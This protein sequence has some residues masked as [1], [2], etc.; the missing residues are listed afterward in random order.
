MKEY[1]VL[2]SGPMIC[3]LLAGNKTQTR[4]TFE[5][6]KKRNPGE[7]LWVREKFQFIQG[8][9]D[10]DFGIHY[11]ATEDITEWIDNEGR[12]PQTVNEKIR[13]SIHMPR[14]AS[15]IN[16]EIVSIREERLQ[17]IS[18]EDAM[19]EGCDPLVGGYPVENLYLDY[20]SSFKLLWESI[21]GP[22][23]WD[24]NPMVYA[25]KFKMVV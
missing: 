17:D 1:P 13:P 19:A 4:R 25:I 3:A 5:I 21:N 15:R 11:M 6:W 22:S 2:F 12:V 10:F 16:L 7:R 18:E 24:A 8:F 9:G 23:S 20:K 14:W